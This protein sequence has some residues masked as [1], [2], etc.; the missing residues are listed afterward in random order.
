[1]SPT[2]KKILIVEDEK[3][4]QMH[5]TRI[6]ESSGHELV[7]AVG[8]SAD[9]LENAEHNR[10]DLVLMDIRLAHGDD[11][12]ECARKLSENTGAAIVF[13]T[14]HSDD[15]TLARAMPVGAAGYLV[16]PFRAAEVSA[17]ISTALATREREKRSRDRERILTSAIGSFEEA[18]IVLDSRGVIG[19]ANPKG[20]LLA[21][22]TEIDGQDRTLLDCVDASERERTQAAI[23]ESLASGT[24]LTLREVQL[25]RNGAAN[26]RLEHVAEAGEVCLLVTI[27]SSRSADP[28]NEAASRDDSSPR[29]MVYSHDT[30]G[31]GHIRRCLNLVRAMTESIENLSTLIVTG[32][33]VAH[34]FELPPRTDY[35]KLPAVRKVAPNSYEPRS[36]AMTDEGI[37]TLRRNLLLRTIQ[38]YKPNLLLVDHSPTGMN[39]ELRPVLEHLRE[40]GHCQRILG[41]RDII[42]SPQRVAARWK[43]ENMIE[44]LKRD[45]DHVVVYGA[46]NVYDTATEYALPDDLKRRTRFVNYVSQRTGSTDAVQV[47]REQGLVVVSIGGGDGGGDSIVRPFLEMMHAHAER[48]GIHAEVLL[49]P[50]VPEPLRR[51]LR[52]LAENTPAVLHDFIPDPTPLFARAELVISTAGYNVS[53]ELLAHA[54]RALLIPRVVHREEQLVRARRL[55]ELGLVDFLH[56]RD[57]TSEAI[58][59][60]VESALDD[61]TLSLASARANNVVP[62]DGAQQMTE[63]VRK[64]VA[65]RVSANPG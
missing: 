18:L 60:R 58:A 25:A 28:A 43:K 2:A 10:P 37:L 27:R 6:I 64:L 51:E 7:G 56:P 46:K 38:D 49:G 14:A 31:L 29:L 12:I 54:N 35:L 30:F 9:A 36:L 20:K 24:A 39:G 5:L 53:A 21:D 32:S 47:E 48:L 15:E 40:S 8:R 1:M 26:I 45:Y 52:A 22:W 50:F 17:S 57:A 16:K 61:P 42:D 44:V 59:H 33:P 4:V 23:S 3:I 63:F 19:F 41:L 11:G 65:R 55:A 34:K 13:V 62:L